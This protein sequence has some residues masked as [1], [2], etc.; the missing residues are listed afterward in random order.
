MW[1]TFDKTRQKVEKSPF[2]QILLFYLNTLVNKPHFFYLTRYLEIIR[3]VA[4]R[5]TEHGILFQYISVYFYLKIR[6]TFNEVLVI[7]DILALW[8]GRKWRQLKA[9]S[10]I[11]G[12]HRGFVWHCWYKSSY[13]FKLEWTWQIVDHLGR[14]WNNCL[15]RGMKCYH[16]YLARKK[17]HE[18]HTSQRAHSGNRNVKTRSKTKPMKPSNLQ[19]VENNVTKWERCFLNVDAN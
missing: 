15:E 4:D 1:V 7:V 2:G 5:D 17:Q 14:M 11:N 19:K 16:H 18:A 8:S 13:F 6:S 9:S 12:T 10:V 3:D